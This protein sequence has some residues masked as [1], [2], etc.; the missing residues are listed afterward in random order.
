[1]S[2]RK[3]GKTTLFVFDLDDTLVDGNA[4]TW[5][6]HAVSGAVERVRAEMSDRGYKWREFENRLLA[7]LHREGA[8]REDILQHM[9]K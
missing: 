5:V 1:M 4:D 7:L 9:K 3:M 8:S 6:G 2:Y